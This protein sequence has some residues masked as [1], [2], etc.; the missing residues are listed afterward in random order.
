MEMFI[1]EG[2]MGGCRYASLLWSLEGISWNLDYLARV[3]RILAKLSRLYPGGRYSNHPYS[4]LRRIFE[5]WLPQTKATLDDRLNVIDSLITYE[6][7][8]GWKLLLNLL[9]EK[10]GGI[11]TPIHRPEFREWN[12][13]WKPGS[14][15]GEYHKHI[16]AIVER[17]LI[18]IDEDPNV[19]W[20]EFIGKIPQLPN[21]CFNKALDKLRA[22]STDN[23][24]DEAVSKIHED[25]KEIVSLNRRFSKADWALTEEAV[26]QLEKILIEFAPSDI[27]KRYKFL[28]DT[29]FPDLPNIDWSQDREKRYE[30]IEQARQNALRDIWSIQNTSGIEH[31]IIDAKI[32]GTVGISLGNSSFANEIE[33]MV[34]GWLGNDNV[35]STPGLQFYAECMFRRFY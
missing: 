27:V 33:A 4:S 34:L 18:H 12:D 23:F 10:G 11:S 7:E 14:M 20:P 24:S 15:K 28:F 8:S 5:G 1:D 25:L 35:R 13:G 3:A 16:L 6:R 22:E 21:E 30:L 19:R 17:V 31:L 9:P 2:N 29:H 26:D 32:P